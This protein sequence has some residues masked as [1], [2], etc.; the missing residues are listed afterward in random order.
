MK[1]VCGGIISSMRSNP[2]K[3]SLY[4]DNECIY[5]C[6]VYREIWF[7]HGAVV[8]A[9]YVPLW[10][11]WCSSWLYIYEYIFFFPSSQRFIHLM[12]EKWIPGCGTCWLRVCGWLSCPRTIMRW[13]RCVASAREWHHVCSASPPIP[14][15]WVFPCPPSP[16]SR[17]RGRQ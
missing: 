1:Q 12:R 5:I 3:R 14:Y 10:L 2:W 13:W 16:P 4:E 9:V 6:L 11:R 15:T 8:L 17:G 7:F